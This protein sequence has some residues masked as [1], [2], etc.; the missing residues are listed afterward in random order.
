[1]KNLK[2][3][4]RAVYLDTLWGEYY[5]LEPFLLLNHLRENDYLNIYDPEIAFASL[6]FGNLKKEY[7]ATLEI[8]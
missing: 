7:K 5:V 4:K 3:Q 6:E 8:H 2:E 1:M